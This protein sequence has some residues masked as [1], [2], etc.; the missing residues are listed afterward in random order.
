[1]ISAGF[2]A[3]M[4]FAMN[5]YWIPNANETRLDFEDTYVKKVKSEYVRNVQMEIEPG[6]VMYIERYNSGNRN[7]NNFFLESYDGQQLVSRLTAKKIRMHTDKK[8]HWVL[9][10][11]MIREFNGLYEHISNGARL[12]TVIKVDPS[13]F[14][15][16]KGWSEQLTTPELKQYLDR[17]KNRGVANIKEYD[18]EYYRRFSFPF[19]CF[20]LTIIG[21]TLASRK[22]RGGMGLHLGLGLLISFTYILLDTISGSFAMGGGLSPLIAVWFPNILYSIIAAILYIKTPK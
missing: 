15:I 7:G 13:E 19:S 16:V 1:M 22:V 2:L 12:D 18:V 17:Q 10:D 5:S 14:Y 11:Y 21:V 20:I 8:Y 4:M 9:S 6:V 3:I